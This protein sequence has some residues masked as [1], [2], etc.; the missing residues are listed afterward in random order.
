M[1]ITF[2]FLDTNIL[3]RFVTQ[4][5][6]GCEREWWDLLAGFVAEKAVRLI[7]PE[8]VL[9][10]FEAKVRNLRDDLAGKISGVREKVVDES[11]KSIKW[12]EIGDLPDFLEA[13]ISQWM[14]SKIADAESRR[15]EVQRLLA[16]SEAIRLP[17]DHEVM[18]RS[19][20]RMLA[21]R[22]KT[23]KDRGDAD[24][25]IMESLVRFFEGEGGDRQL[26]LCT[27]NHKDFGVETK[28]GTKILHPLMKDG[29]PPTELFTDLASM[30]GFIEEHKMVVEPGPNEVKEAVEREKAEENEEAIEGLLLRSAP[31][32][33]L[34]PKG[35]HAVMRDMGWTSSMPWTIDPDMLRAIQEAREIVSTS[36]MLNPTTMSMLNDMVKAASM[37]PTIHPTT[38]RMLNNMVKAA[39]Y[40][41][42]N[43][44]PEAAGNVRSVIS[45]DDVANLAEEPNPV[46]EQ[47]ESTSPPPT[48][49]SPPASSPQSP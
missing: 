42:A 15:D 49:S 17:F 44:I 47:K 27:E 32:Y 19:R 3:F 28:E 13:T 22:V 11:R 6:P 1:P 18:F 26:L 25:F 40:H 48:A 38:L 14:Q 29:L 21:G 9:L 39:P 35:V 2:V 41:S 7:V 43:K 37:R 12:N 16:S 46:K 4:G 36:P 5:Q 33:E 31:P 45:T 10:E 8:V 30:V 24:C 23:S 20:R 34:I